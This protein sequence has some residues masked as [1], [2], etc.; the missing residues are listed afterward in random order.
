MSSKKNL[1]KS[2]KAAAFLGVSRDTIQYWVKAGRLIPNLIS[3]KGYYFFSEENLAAVLDQLKQQTAAKTGNETATTAATVLK[4]GN[5]NVQNAQNETKA[6]NETG[7]NAQCEPVVS[8]KRAM[9]SL[10]VLP[11]QHFSGVTKLMRKLQVVPIGQGFKTAFDRTGNLYTFARLD[12]AD[13]KV[14]FSGRFDA[15]DE[16]ILNAIYSITRSAQAD[17]D[18]NYAVGS[19]PMFSSRRILQ[20]IFGN[21]ADHFQDEIVEFVEKRLERLSW[22]KLTFDLRDS[23]GNSQSVVVRGVRYRPAALRENLLDMSVIDF[24]NETRERRFPVYKL[25]RKSPIFMYAEKLNQVTSWSAH[26]MAVPCRKTIQNALIAI[27]FLTRFSL[28]KNKS[29]HYL[30]T[31]VLFETFF[32]DLGLD[33]TTRKKKKIIRDTVKIMFD[34]WQKVGLIISYGFMKMGQAFH[35]IVFKVNLTEAEKC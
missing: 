10:P 8:K 22:M 31:G 3:E 30:N 4:T 11:S 2:G 33:V 25:H 19:K 26:Y 32:E 16:L 35:K 6:G 18:G 21:V 24:E 29:N 28:I 12:Y 17:N 20:H 5:E 23:L 14:S 1:M 9:V 7:Q 15:A 13:E 34:Y 27:Y